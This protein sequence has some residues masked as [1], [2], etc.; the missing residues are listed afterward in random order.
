MITKTPVTLGTSVRK[1]AG[2]GVPR[3]GVLSVF[4][5]QVSRSARIAV[6][7][8]GLPAVR[9]SVVVCPTV[10]STLMMAENAVFPREE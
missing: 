6:N 9:A 10:I 5:S 8:V 1:F 3:R 4:A 7:I 2:S